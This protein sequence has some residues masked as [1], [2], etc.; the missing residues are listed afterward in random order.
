MQFSVDFDYYQT[1]RHA[2][3]LMSTLSNIGGLIVMLHPIF[4]IF[5]FGLGKINADIY[6]VTKMFK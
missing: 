1:K 2:Q 3:D 6:F 5:V 4:R